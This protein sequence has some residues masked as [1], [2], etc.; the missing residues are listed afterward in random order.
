[1]KQTSSALT[2][3]MAQYRA[4]F[5]RAYIKGIA[6]AILLTAGL[7]AGQAQA[8]TAYSSLNTINNVSGDTI[9]ID[10]TASTP[11]TAAIVVK[12]G[13]TLNKDV[14][15]KLGE[16]SA[17]TLTASGSTVGENVVMN[18]GGNDFTINGYSGDNDS[19]TFGAQ[20]ADEKLQIK[21]LGTLKIQNNAKVI[22]TAGSGNAPAAGAGVDVYADTIEVNNSTVDILQNVSGATGQNAILR[23]KTINVSGS[24]AVINLGS[25]DRNGGR[26]TLGWRSE[27]TLADNDKP[28][29][30]T[31]GSNISLSGGATL[32]LI[33]H[34][35]GAANSYNT[36]GSQVWGNSLIANKSF[37]EVS[38]AGAQ[39]WTHTNKFTDTS[40][41]VA[42][43][44]QLIIKPF[45]FR[46]MKAGGGTDN[47]HAFSFING[48]TT[49]DG[50]NLI[51]EGNLL[52]AGTVVINDNVNLTAGNAALNTASGNGNELYN[53]VLTVGLGS[54]ILND[55]DKAIKTESILKISSTKLDEFLTGTN[56]ETK[57]ND[58]TYKDKAGILSFGAGKV[59]LAFTDDS[60]VDLHDFNWVKTDMSKSG[61]G[62]S[63]VA[64]SIVY[65]TKLA[66]Q[67]SSGDSYKGET[68]GVTVSATNLLVSDALGSGAESINLK[69]TNLT[70]GSNSYNGTGS[71]NFSGATARNLNVLAKSGDFLLNDTVT[72]RSISGTDNVVAS[73]GTIQGDLA[74]ASGKTFTVDGGIYQTNDDFTVNAS[75][76][77]AV[78]NTKGANQSSLDL[79]R[80]INFNLSSAGEAKVTVDGGLTN[81]YQAGD[82]TFGKLTQLDLR[83]GISA[84]GT[85]GSAKISATSGG[86]VLVDGNDLTAI[87]AAAGSADK[88]L[89]K[90]SFEIASGAALKA[91]GNVQ[92][93]FTDANATTL[94][95]MLDLKKGGIFEA[96][97]LNIEAKFSSDKGTS[98]G[99]GFTD[100]TVRVG[101]LSFT[102]N[103]PDADDSF[104]TGGTFEIS[105]SLTV[106]NTVPLTLAA[107]SEVAGDGDVTLKF[108]TGSNTATGTISAEDITNSSA[109]GE[110][111]FA[112]GAWTSNTDFNLSNGTMTVGVTGSQDTASLTA[113][114]LS[115]SGGGSFNVAA[116][117]GSATFDHLDAWWTDGVNVAGT[118]TINGDDVT[119]ETEDNPVAVHTN[120]N[121]IKVA[122][123]G[124]LNFGSKAVYNSIFGGTSG[125]TVLLKNS[126]A[127]NT[128]E[129][130]A[131]GHVSLAFNDTTSLSAKQ[132]VDLKKKLF[133]N[134]TEGSI[135]GFINL[136]DAKIEDLKFDTDAN[137]TPTITWDQ[138]QPVADVVGAGT[139][140][141]ELAEAKVTGISSTDQFKSPVGSVVSTDGSVTV[142]GNSSFNNAAGN[143]GLFVSDTTG[144]VGN[145]TVGNGSDLQLNGSGEIGTVSLNGGSATDQAVLVTSNG[146]TNAP[147]KVTVAS[148]SGDEHSTFSSRAAET[149]VTGDV[150]VGSIET[151]A[152]TVTTVGGDVKVAGKADFAGT[153]DI[154]GN[155]E[156]ADAVDFSG[157]TTFGGDVEI[158]G[159]ANITGNTTATAGDT[160]LSGN[161][162]IAEGA[163]FTAN[164]IKL[165]SAGNQ[166]LAVG[167]E[168]TTDENGEEQPGTTGYLDV[169]TLS[170]NG[171]MLVVDPDYGEATSIAAIDNFDTAGYADD[172]SAINGTVVVGQNAALMVGADASKQAMSDFIERYQNGVSLDKDNVG[173][174]VYLT[175]AQTVT[176]TSRIII[177]PTR[178]RD[179]ILGTSTTT[180]ELNAADSDYSGKDAAGNSHK[181]DLY[182]GK[183]SVLAIGEGAVTFDKATTANGAVHFD[184]DSA[185]IKGETGSKVVLVGDSFLNSRTITLFTDKGAA[186]ETNGVYVMNNDIRVESLNGL[187]YF[188][189]NADKET[190]GKELQ[191]DTTKVDSAFNG[192]SSPMRNFLLSYATRTVNYNEYYS[193]TTKV[194]RVYLL[195]GAD[196]SLA[197]ASDQDTVTLTDKATQLGLTEDDFVV[198]NVG[199]KDKPEY[200]AY[201]LANNQ[202]LEKV[203]RDTDGAAADE[204]ARMGAFGG[205]AQAALMAASTTTDAIAGRMGMGLTNAAF[206]ASDN[207]QGAGLW[208]TPIYKNSDSDGFE[209]D[210]MSYGADVD[211]YGVS[212]GGDYT[213]ANGLRIGAMFNVGSGEADGQGDASNVTNDFNYYGFGLY[214]GYSMGAFSIVGDVSYSVVDSDVDASTQV[215]KVTTSFDT[216]ALSLG[217]TAQYSL[218]LNGFAVVPHAGLR[219]TSLDMDDY[220]LDGADSGNIGNF[221]ADT[222]GIFSIPVG[223]TVAKE[224][225]SESWTVKPALDLT[226]TG[227]FG[228]D[229]L[230]GEVNWTGVSNRNV[231]TE[232]E[233]VDNFTYSAALGVAAQNGNFS[234]GLGVNY[235]G[236]SNV[237]EFG[238]NANARFTF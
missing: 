217:V 139:G 75:G 145:A 79:N 149:A 43:N 171:K 74:I 46:V 227:N 25:K 81:E 18:G 181:A 72:L 102:N 85:S 212:L 120:A 216:A 151:L 154:K 187:M 9:T 20:N 142:A 138:L 82:E 223:V 157:I 199:T 88:A 111:I 234:F 219:Y 124:T 93:S 94:N 144:K 143:N 115:L 137:G 140:N 214:A 40:F 29:S 6:T 186:N 109:K 68:V 97:S 89:S 158:T 225:T 119:V 24:N 11:D 224:F 233:I 130:E 76:T 107:A 83:D 62:N 231:A 55:N 152:N 205:A 237:D 78:T 38:G 10:G 169:A 28:G 110:I 198:R 65:D 71:L 98:Q 19:F 185:Y 7:A 146:S 226:L 32:N 42:N 183:N 114:E 100:A 47:E 166:V 77:L 195:D 57:V 133:N 112:Q 193:D 53:G 228:D 230:D 44:A 4:I 101:S 118:L 64:G 173:A 117:V 5:K 189:L 36:Q 191:L 126:F 172:I 213:L 3:L 164:S 211:L 90:V 178:S 84:S 153:T 69:A 96:D 37:V 35:G 188:T 202:F 31:S 113:Y 177:D 123:T 17:F 108:D 132:I 127:E 80:G 103:T 204:A 125:D 66:G 105:N 135:L 26:A 159:E 34:T 86:V 176:N 209:A 141:N 134:D 33:G 167:T 179:A 235:T 41:H 23:G 197:T 203:V 174:V 161:M 207:G 196:K 136:G 51:V 54:E 232:S 150:D 106:G 194:K 148:V 104:L 200:V 180:G 87:F 58:K 238:V 160:S 8:A 30:I 95:G 70:L 168:T 221:D 63:A 192:S 16:S 22:V 99:L 162:T 156:F 73:D 1:M 52:A 12:S 116:S 45:E 229:T 208:L 91:E 15:F 236:S 128:I 121:S 2:F 27:A 50:G 201:R 182:I 14:V 218:D 190:T 131:N 222:A 61:S 67:K 175:S 210:G 56:T 48:T 165:D 184:K 13:D 220:D 170:L 49:F 129:L 92:M 215:E 59:T 122:S 163:A 206:T 60:Q 21:N 155:A 39:I 147:A